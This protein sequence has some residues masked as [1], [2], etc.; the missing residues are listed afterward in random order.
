M[1]NQSAMSLFPFSFAKSNGL[2]F[3]GVTNKLLIKIDAP[4]SAL[5]EAKRTLGFEPELES[6]SS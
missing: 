3:D 1:D 2:L 6:L 5:L 4:I